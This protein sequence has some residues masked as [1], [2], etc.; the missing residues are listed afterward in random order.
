MKKIKTLQVN[1]F[2]VATRIAIDTEGENKIV[3]KVDSTYYYA[4]KKYN[5]YSQWYTINGNTYV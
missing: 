2:G 3:N 5:S 1:D 4:D